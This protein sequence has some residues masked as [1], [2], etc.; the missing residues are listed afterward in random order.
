M[1]LSPPKT[2][3][4]LRRKHRPWLRVLMLCAL[5]CIT[6]CRSTT[7]APDAPLP[8]VR[9]KSVLVLPFKNMTAVYGPDFSVVCPLCGK[10]FTTGKVE[11]D[12]TE[13]LTAHL[14]AKLRARESLE[15]I[16]PEEGRGTLSALLSGGGRE[17]SEHDLAIE[18]GR[19][20]QVDGVMVGYVYRFSERVGAKYSVESPASVTFDLDLI[21]VPDGRLLWSGA[22]N[23]TQKSLFEDLFQLGTF[24]KRKGAWL[25][26]AQLAQAGMDDVL[27]TL[28]F[29]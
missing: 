1:K 26:A 16:S 13:L 12:A 6:G 7:S 14:V 24:L 19:R 20:M 17:L 3:T 2:G 4:P 18:A 21:H 15:V 29:L 27:A 8:P 5:G 10:V 22:F 11:E 25:T 9:L 23:E 28:D